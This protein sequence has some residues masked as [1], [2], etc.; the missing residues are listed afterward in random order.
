MRALVTG[1]TGFIGS[2]LVEAL[3]A[4]GDE[5][6]CLARDRRNLR[7]LKSCAGLDIVE[8]DVTDIPALRAAVAGVGCVYH[9]AGVTRARRARDFFRI[10]A[11]GTRNLVTACIKAEGRP[12]RF[13]YVSSLAAVGP[14]ADTI[15]I[16]EDAT[17]RP[18]SAYGLSKLRGEEEVL[19]A[20]GILHVTV[21]RP[22]VVYGPRDRGLYSFARWVSRGL[23]PMPAGP[24]RFL[25]LCYVDDLVRAIIASSMIPVSGETYHL[26][27]DR[28]LT[29]L[30]IGGTMGQAMDLRPRPLRLPFSVLLCMAAGFEVWGR[31]TGRI[32]FLTRGKVRE[33]FGQWVCDPAK[34]RQ[35]LGFVP[36]VSPEE[37]MRLTVQWYRSQGWI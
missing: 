20:R 32:A 21:M 15:P 30:D 36:R 8:G 10:N 34:A 17:P 16:R 9:L 24:P 13:V 2:H 26:T 22:G 31:A 5:V 1:A 18:V 28:S 12:P 29:W 14:R 4:R 11:E 35:H 7:W 19:A 37:G 25:S 33:A 3:V 27:G 6:L 23:L